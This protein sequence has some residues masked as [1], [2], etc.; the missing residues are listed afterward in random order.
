VWIP[1]MNMS[2]NDM[3][4]IV[5]F[6]ERP[7][8]EMYALGHQVGFM[9]GLSGF[10]VNNPARCLELA[11]SL[12]RVYMTPRH[13][14]SWLRGWHAGVEDGRIEKLKTAELSARK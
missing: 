2:K 13:D 6:P 12:G 4:N 9:C 10:L 14:R 1:A 5:N 8:M 7:M 11:H 3:T